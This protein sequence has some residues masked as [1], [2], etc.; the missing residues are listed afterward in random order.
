[1]SRIKYFHDA[2]AFGHSY[3]PLL[4]LSQ[5]ATLLDAVRESALSGFKDTDGKVP[6]RVYLCSVD[7]DCDILLAMKDAYPYYSITQVLNNRFGTFD[8]TLCDG[9]KRWMDDLK[10]RSVQIRSSSAFKE[11]EQFFQTSK[12]K[13]DYLVN[14]IKH[15]RGKILY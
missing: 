1:L 5:T 12:A 10:T 8:Q 3:M 6:F 7:P 15:K 9:T 11:R 4:L 13:I 14:E 2:G